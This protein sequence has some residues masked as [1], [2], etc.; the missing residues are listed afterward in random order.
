MTTDREQ[1]IH[2]YMYLQ[3]KRDEMLEVLTEA[4][5]ALISTVTHNNTH[6]ETMKAICL[7]RAK[8]G[9][10]NAEFER[11]A[12]IIAFWDKHKDAYKAKD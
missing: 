12:N 10:L 8:Y 3:D 1:I 4:Y 9:D 2:E 6:E 5:T 7:I 11:N